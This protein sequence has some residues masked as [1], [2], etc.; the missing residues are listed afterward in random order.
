[1]EIEEMK[2]LWENMS[3]ELDRQKLLTDKMVLEMTQKKYKDTLRSISLPETAG[4][5]ICFAMA[6]FI[7]FNFGKLDTWYLILCGLVSIGFCVIL[8]IL[9]MQSIIRMK[10]I[11][12]SGNSY[13]ES[14]KQYAHEKRQFIKVQKTAYY[15]GFV[16]ALTVLPVFGKIMKDK[17]FL[18]DSKLWIWYIPMAVIFH[19]LFSKWVY[20]HYTSI[21]KGAQKLLDDLNK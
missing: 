6:L 1:M 4:A 10:K 13:K 9:S 16:F 5:I 12:V 19:F 20:R 21:T 3:Q 7:I 8:P 2:T 15:F 18:L 14:L 17:D 11:D